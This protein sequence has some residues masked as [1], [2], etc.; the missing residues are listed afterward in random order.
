MF[1]ENNN[2][3]P[4][5]DFLLSLDQATIPKCLKA[6]NVLENYGLFAGYPF[7]KKITREIFELRI[8]GQNEIRFLFTYKNDM[9]YLLHGFK[10]KRQKLLPKD[11]KIAQNRLTFI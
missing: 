3:Q 7:I 8:K 4:V 11:I 5:E 2:R 6:I 10:K 1:F 9:F